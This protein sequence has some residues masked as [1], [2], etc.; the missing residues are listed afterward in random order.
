MRFRPASINYLTDA[1]VH[2]RHEKALVNIIVQKVNDEDRRK[3]DGVQE[4]ELDELF[5][6]RSEHSSDGDDFL[7]RNDTDDDEDETPS[8]LVS[9]ANA[10]FLFLSMY[11]LTP[12]FL[13]RINAKDQRSRFTDEGTMLLS[14]PPNTFVPGE[15][16]DISFQPVSMIIVPP[17]PVA[18]RIQ[19]FLYLSQRR[20][21]LSNVQAWNDRGKIRRHRKKRARIDYNHPIPIP[22]LQVIQV[23]ASLATSDLVSLQQPPDRVVK[24]QFDQKSLQ[25]QAN[26]STLRQEEVRT[27]MRLVF[28]I[29]TRLIELQRNDVDNRRI[30]ELL[31]ETNLIQ[32]SKVEVVSPAP[33]DNFSLVEAASPC[34]HHSAVKRNDESESTCASE[35]LGLNYCIDESHTYYMGAAL[36]F[37]KSPNLS[38]SDDMQI[39]HAQ[40]DEIDDRSRLNDKTPITNLLAKG[41]KNLDF[42]LSPS[43]QSPQGVPSEEDSIQDFEFPV[44]SCDEDEIDNIQVS[45]AATQG[46]EDKHDQEADERCKEKKHKKK[47]KKKQKKSKK[48]KRNRDCDDEHHRNSKRHRET[49]NCQAESTPI[50]KITPETVRRTAR[51]VRN[52]ENVRPTVD[53]HTLFDPRVKRYNRIQNGSF[54]LKHVNRD[55][56]ESKTGV[57]IDPNFTPEESA[58]KGLHN[59]PCPGTPLNFHSFVELDDDGLEIPHE[60]PEPATKLTCHD[61]LG[62]MPFTLPMIA[63]Q[64][65]KQA[66]EL[67]V[68]CS[69]SFVESSSQVIASLASGSWL[70]DAPV[71]EGSDVADHFSFYRVMACDSSLLDEIGIDMEIAGKGAILVQRLSTWGNQQDLKVLIREMVKLSALGRYLTLHLIICVDV[72]LSPSL[73]K[74]I[75]IVQSTPFGNTDCIV[76][77]QLVAP[78]ALAATIAHKVYCAKKQSRAD[79][80]KSI[81]NS[82]GEAHWQTSFLL[83]LIS[84]LTVGDTLL[85]LRGTNGRSACTLKQVLKDSHGSA[86]SDVQ[87]QLAA[88]AQLNQIDG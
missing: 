9:F 54:S 11:D 52:L 1:S 69:E 19:W 29:T 78:G 6:L 46:M 77:F 48:T 81:F 4:D 10:S 41:T 67:H 76:S 23:F 85:L 20:K 56:G 33:D 64:H 45:E 61:R 60:S 7:P 36:P 5:E 22:F 88:H 24:Q 47:K 53:D 32:Q 12:V 72:V 8:Y 40:Q 74:D 51:P 28:P 57:L 68:L 55:T 16:L 39:L 75:A 14:G 13:P 15:L 44:H 42:V 49:R 82:I 50:S 21:L 17:S 58:T 31:T 30:T 79:I 80:H 59:S 3:E 35:S 34:F 62:R 27:P 2:H 26:I 25:E 86:R 18:W 37:Y 84:S 73:A 66:R 87:L 71:S 65:D 63:G 70:V 83:R 43:K 38:T